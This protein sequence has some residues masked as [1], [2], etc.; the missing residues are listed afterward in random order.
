[1]TGDCPK[2]GESAKEAEVV[3]CKGDNQCGGLLGV[4][5]CPGKEH[6]RLKCGLCGYAEDRAPLDQTTNQHA[7]AYWD[8]PE[9]LPV[10]VEESKDKTLNRGKAHG[11]ARR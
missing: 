6:I 5:P 1:M 4:G 7:S 11:G 9:Q 2:C 10:M 3:W 8:D